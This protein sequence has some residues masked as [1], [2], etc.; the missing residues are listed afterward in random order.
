MDHAVA[1]GCREGQEEDSDAAEQASFWTAEAR[2]LTETGQDILKHGQLCGEGGKYHKQEEEG[3]PYPAAL[4]VV[5]YSC[6]GIKE[7]SR[8]GAGFNAIGIACGKDDKTGHDGNKGIQQNNM[9]GLTKEGVLFVDIASEDCHSAD[10]DRQREKCLI[11]GRN[12]H[13]S[14]DF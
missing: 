14:V 3:S 2:N 5:E 10:A 13:G 11:H 6:H 8:S 4:H 1:E 9:K 7:Q 12:D